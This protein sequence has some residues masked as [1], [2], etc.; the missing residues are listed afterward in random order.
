MIIDPIRSGN[1]ECG[2]GKLEVGNGKSECGSGNLEVES[3]NVKV[4]KDHG[5]W[6]FVLCNE[7]VNVLNDPNDHNALNDPNEHNDPNDPN[8]IPYRIR[9]KTT[10]SKTRKTRKSY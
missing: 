8:G 4:G 5:Y 1:A 9:A 2:S 7:G 6:L 3:R 10:G